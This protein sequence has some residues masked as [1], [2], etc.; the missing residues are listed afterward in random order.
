MS[1]KY[2]NNYISNFLIRLDLETKLSEGEY[3]KLLSLLTK[4]FPINEKRDIQNR[5]IVINTDDKNNPEPMLSEPELKVQNILYN[6]ERTERVTINSD[7]VL[8]ES[9]KYTSFTIIKPI[10]EKIIDCL[11][12]EYGIK[13]FNRIGLRYV[14][15]IKLP[16]KDRNQI[17]DWNGYINK[18]I[19][20]DTS[21]IDNKNLLQEIKS[22][23]FK[24]D[25]DNNLLCRLQTGIPNR[26]MPADLMEKIYLIDI[27]GYTNSLVEQ[28]DAINILTEIHDKN[29]EVFEKCIDD[30]LR[31]D[32]DE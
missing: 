13:N 14:N 1:K 29:I 10:L 24:L 22:I 2:K 27:D 12:K 11:N 16:I 7:S 5:N 4:D 23:D 25:S 28:E 18:K 32:M 8:Y 19:L 3:D 15:L 31:G 6:T 26:N 9:L 21:F 30:K 17:F 20:F